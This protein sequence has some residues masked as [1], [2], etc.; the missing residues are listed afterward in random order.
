MTEAAA[1]EVSAVEAKENMAAYSV[2]SL[3]RV[4]GCL[5]ASFAASFSYF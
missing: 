4:M 1:A 2:D 5:V 3:S